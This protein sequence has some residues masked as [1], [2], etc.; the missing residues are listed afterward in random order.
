MI[1]TI[2]RSYGVLGHEKQPVYTWGAGGGEIYDK[3]QVELPQAAGVDQFGEPLLEIDGLTYAFSELLTN[4]GDK[5]AIIIP[6]DSPH[7]RYKVL[8]EIL[9]EKEDCHD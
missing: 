3:I 4:Y 6:G 8:R 9:P 1:V 7:S 5:P 2:F